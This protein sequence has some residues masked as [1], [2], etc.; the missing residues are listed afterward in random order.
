MEILDHIES[1]SAV[2]DK[3]K[4]EHPSISLTIGTFDGVHLG[5]QAVL[6]ALKKEGALRIVLTFSN[7]PS[8]VLLKTKPLRLLT[9]SHKIHLL[10]ESGIDFIIMIPFTEALSL[11]SPLEFLTYLR[12]YIPF[13]T[14]VLGH[15][16]VIGHE[17]SGTRDVLFELAKQLQ[18]QAIYVE[19]VMIEDQIISSSLIRQLIMRGEFDQANRF[20]GHAYSIRNYVESGHQIGK[21]LGFQTA[22]L[23]VSE[24]CTP[25]FGVYIVEVIFQN[26]RWEGVAWEGVANLGFAPT[27]HSNR[28]PILEVHILDWNA[29]IY[30]EIIEVV[31]LQFLRQEERFASFSELQNQIEIDVEATRRFFASNQKP[32]QI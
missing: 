13:S 6:Q 9:L 14:L 8:E 20:L 24:I 32:L 22:N 3:W 31:F 11:Q 23:D 21:K 25:P 1:F 2:I 17:R 30:G 15:D 28:K 5:H 29:H 12:K 18:F 19:P 26:D 27:T 4:E 7:H 16:A 10:A